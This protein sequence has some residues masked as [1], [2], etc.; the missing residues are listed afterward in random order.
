MDNQGEIMEYRQSRAGRCRENHTRD[1][2]IYHYGS[3]RN[4]EVLLR[5]G[6]KGPAGRKGGGRNSFSLIFF[7]HVCVCLSVCVCVC[8]CISLMD[9]K[10]FT[11]LPTPSLASLLVSSSSKNK[12]IEKLYNTWLIYFFLFVRKCFIYLKSRISEKKREN[13][14]REGRREKK[15]SPIFFL[16]LV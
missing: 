13:E 12:T 15:K 6:A 14:R 7:T 1:L 4:V 9:I 3:E 2:S 10:K 8:V 5:Y 11:T 16:D